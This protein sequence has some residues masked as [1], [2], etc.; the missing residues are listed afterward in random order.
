MGGPEAVRLSLYN[1]CFIDQ[2]GPQGNPK[3]TFQRLG[4]H[5]TSINPLLPLKRQPHVFLLICP[6]NS[7]ENMRS[8]GIRAAAQAD[9]VLPPV[10]QLHCPHCAFIRVYPSLAGLLLGEKL[11]TT[12]YLL[13]PP[14]SPTCTQAS[15][16][17]LG[18]PRSRR[19]ET[20]RW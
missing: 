11:P 8:M 2:D 18:R 16:S 3:Q 15:S 4:T 6:K 7:W 1:L 19:A 17:R 12:L 20:E 9:S 10:R 5:K 13:D 14:V